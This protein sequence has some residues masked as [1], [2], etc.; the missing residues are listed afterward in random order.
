MLWWSG[1]WATVLIAAY[2]LPAIFFWIVFLMELFGT[3]PVKCFIKQIYNQ[4]SHGFHSH[5]VSYKGSNIEVYD[6]EDLRQREP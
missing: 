6:F 1:F 4:Q 2:A 3:M 5:G